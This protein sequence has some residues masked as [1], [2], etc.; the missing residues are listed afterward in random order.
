MNDPSHPITTAPAGVRVQATYRGEVIADSCEAVVLREA[1]YP[2]VYY[3]PRKDVR[4][5]R[6]ERSERRTHC[7]YKG[8]ASYYSLKDGPQNAAW[9]YETP[10][11]DMA[12]IAGLLAFY[13]DKFDIRTR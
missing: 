8:D 1:S 10:H 12:A 2:A 6:F 7:P 11:G 9:S 3:F 4:M 13:P 5:A